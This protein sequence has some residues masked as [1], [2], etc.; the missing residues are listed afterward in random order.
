MVI[1]YIYLT[2][3]KD[4]ILLKVNDH[5]TLQQRENRRIVW[6]DNFQKEGKALEMFQ[7]LEERK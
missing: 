6:Q 7:Q 2:H 1:A 4:I 3:E 5:W